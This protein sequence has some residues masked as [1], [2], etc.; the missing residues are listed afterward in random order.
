MSKKLTINKTVPVENT[1]FKQYLET[2]SRA[3]IGVSQLVAVASI[4]YSSTV[5]VMGV[6]GYLPKVLIIPQ[7]LLAAVIAINKFTK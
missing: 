3:I 6:A 4:A 1:K 5:I 7:V 2:S